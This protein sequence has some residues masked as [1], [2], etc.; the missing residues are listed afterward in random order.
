MKNRWTGSRA[1]LVGCA[2]A[3]AACA[4]SSTAVS[5]TDVAADGAPE[6]E[7]AAPDSDGADG[8]AAPDSELGPY[9]YG[10]AAQSCGAPNQ[11]LTPV[12]CTIH[13]DTLAYCVYGNH[14]ACS[15]GYACEVPHGAGS[16]VECASGSVCVV[17][18]TGET[19]DAGPDADPR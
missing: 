2:L 3:L 13:G 9:Q 7:V 18:P 1:V 15:A 17:A 16:S 5:D 12:D 8:A 14:C 11:E 19:K 4:G 10:Q 6:A